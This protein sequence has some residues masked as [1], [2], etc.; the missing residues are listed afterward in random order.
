M[1]RRVRSGAG[2]HSGAPKGEQQGPVHCTSVT[3]PACGVEWHRLGNCRITHDWTELVQLPGLCRRSIRRCL[4]RQTRTTGRRTTTSSPSH[5]SAHFVTLRP[6]NCILHS[7]RMHAISRHVRHWKV[8]IS[9]FTGTSF[10]G[11]QV[12]MAPDIWGAAG[13]GANGGVRHADLPIRAVALRSG[14]V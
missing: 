1:L 9:A 6:Q 8:I 5:L 14:A 3:P 7:A 12:R 2:T 13:S 10:I 4:T 11:V